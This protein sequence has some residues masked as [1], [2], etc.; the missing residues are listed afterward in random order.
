MRNS[1]DFFNKRWNYF[2]GVGIAF[3]VGILF[4]SFF[5]S[6]LLGLLSLKVLPIHWDTFGA[7]WLFSFLFLLLQPIS[8]IWDSFMEMIYRLWEKKKIMGGY[9]IIFCSKVGETLITIGIACQLDK[10]MDGISASMWTWTMIGYFFVVLTDL[11][12]MKRQKNKSAK[13]SQ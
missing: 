5:F 8:A 10:W 12:A 9:F 1:Y 7:L 11:W 13:N 2:I 3:F 4:I 6:F